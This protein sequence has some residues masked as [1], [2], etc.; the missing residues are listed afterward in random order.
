M[1]SLSVKVRTACD[2]FDLF[3]VIQVVT[4][5]EHSAWE[6]DKSL[7]VILTFLEMLGLRKFSSA[8]MAQKYTD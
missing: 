1:V 8:H 7:W 6:W 3:S 2:L 4:G 5:R